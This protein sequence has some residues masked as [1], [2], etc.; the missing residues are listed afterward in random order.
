MEEA[1]RFELAYPCNEHSD[2]ESDALSQL[3]HASVIGPQGEGRTRMLNERWI[4][5]PVCLPDFHHLGVCLA[6]MSRPVCVVR[7]AGIEP[8]P[9]AFQTDASTWLAWCA[10]YEFVVT[11]A[12]RCTGLLSG[13][14]WWAGPAT[15][16]R[17]SRYEHAAL[18]QLS[19]RP[20]G[21]W[22]RARDSNSW[23]GLHRPPRF[24][25]GALGHSASSPSIGGRVAG[26][27]TQVSPCGDIRISNASR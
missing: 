2:F 13:Q 14:N 3:C 9:S 24:K 17:S 16:R 22:R 18:V 4:L 7:T 5:N 12:E 21:C 15:I 6:G 19:Y 1:A 26:I 27:R 10:M 8:A 23:A 11:T 20:A 25:R